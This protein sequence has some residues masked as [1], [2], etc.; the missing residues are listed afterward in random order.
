MGKEIPVYEITMKSTII[1]CIILCFLSFILSSGVKD[2]DLITAAENGNVDKIRE[3]LALNAD[4]NSKTQSGITALMMASMGGHTDIVKLLIAGEAEVDAKSNRGVTALITAAKE[5]H[6][7]I[8]EILLKYGAN[9]DLETEGGLTALDVAMEEGHTEIVKRLESATSDLSVNHKSRGLISPAADKSFEVLEFEYRI[10]S[11]KSLY[12]RYVCRIRLRNKT[13]RPIG[14]T[15]TF[16]FLDG[17]HQIVYNDTKRDVYLNSGTTKTIT[18]Y[19]PISTDF[20]FKIVDAK[21]AVKLKKTNRIPTQNH[22][23]AW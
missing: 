7:G 1:V 2:T 13:D 17:N 21:P 6:D 18:E 9:A 19:I 23:R 20:A 14:L 16:E 22:Q 8:V 3:L 10:I 15:V 5:G 11:K 12:W 4:V